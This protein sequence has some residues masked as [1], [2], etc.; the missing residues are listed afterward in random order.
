MIENRR[1][2]R[3][4]IKIEKALYYTD[5]SNFRILCEK[6][7]KESCM[8]IWR[9]Q[10]WLRR[11]EYYHTK[12]KKPFYALIFI[13]C[14]RMK[15]HYGARLGISITLNTFDKG[16]KIDHYGSIVIN[17]MCHIGKNCRLHGNNCVGV[18]GTE[19]I[20]EFPEIGDNCDLGFGSV[21]IGNV[22]LGNGIVV[23]ANAV[24]TK[25]CIEDG[26]VLIGSPARRKVK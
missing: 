16:L 15:N 2:Y 26:S 21:V 4:F 3:E 11:A 8:Q 22:K 5:K 18:K 14:M 13:F 10:K 19:R 17:G 23:G 20:G 24:V 1:D 6:I 12:R 7:T 25:S 9:F